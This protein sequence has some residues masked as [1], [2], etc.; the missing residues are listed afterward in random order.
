MAREAGLSG[1]PM[2][3]SNAKRDL[4]YDKRDR[5][6]CIPAFPLPLADKLAPAAPQLPRELAAVPRPVWANPNPATLPAHAGARH[7]HSRVRD[8]I[9]S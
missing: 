7:A 1:V 9:L 2:Y 8:H 6:E 4:F 5:A 3:I